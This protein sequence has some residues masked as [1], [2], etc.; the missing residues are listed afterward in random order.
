MILKHCF[1]GAFS[2]GVRNEMYID[3]HNH[4]E[5]YGEK[6]ETALAIIDRDRIKTVGCAMDIETYLLTRELSKAHPLIVPAFGIHPW[7]AAE[8]KDD[9]E[10]A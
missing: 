3:A 7:R 4:L 8:Y 9:L 6:L 10:G 1:G 2:F 5:Q